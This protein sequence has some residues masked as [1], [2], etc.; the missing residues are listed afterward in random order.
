MSNPDS[1]LPVNPGRTGFNPFDGLCA[2]NTF[3]I[4]LSINNAVGFVS[5]KPEARYVL[6]VVS[7]AKLNPRVKV[8]NS[9]PC[10]ILLR[11]IKICHPRIKSN[12]YLFMEEVTKYNYTICLHSDEPYIYVCALPRVFVD[13]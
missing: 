9:K 6:Y 8:N 10:F 3:I 5:G 12:I 7:K 11:I 13:T 1:S 2:A 4:I